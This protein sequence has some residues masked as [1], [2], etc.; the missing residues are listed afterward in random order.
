[1]TCLE[2]WVTSAVSECWWWS[3]SSVPHKT[4]AQPRETKG[5]PELTRHDGPPASSR[6][7]LSDLR[8][9]CPVRQSDC[10]S[11]E[12]NT[13]TTRNNIMIFHICTGRQLCVFCP[14]F[15]SICLLQLYN[16]T[17]AWHT[18]YYNT[19]H[20]LELTAGEVDC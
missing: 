15:I 14:I 13:N 12:N 1:M 11:H 8:Q 10:R 3:H 4:V 6:D 9:R 17:P 19:Q 7:H 18:Y 20:T 2:G 5:R 16:M